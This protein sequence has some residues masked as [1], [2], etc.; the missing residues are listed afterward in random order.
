MIEILFVCTGNL[1]RSPMA[2]TLL[3]ARV[4]EAGA[5]QLITVVSA[6]LA[7]PQNEPASAGAQRAMRSR[8]L[9]LGT[10]RARQLTLDM[11]DRATLV[12]TMTERHRQSILQAA[13]EA[14]DK[15]RCLKEYAGMGGDV[16]D[17]Y[18][19]SDLIYERCAQEIEG[20]LTASWEKIRL[21]AGK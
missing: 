10:H 9:Q 2:E 5:A 14:A 6:G 19:G 15:V 17:P 21:L 1:C 7:A 13:P 16:D 3:R 20:L 12:L 11:V 18:G 4:G 8:G